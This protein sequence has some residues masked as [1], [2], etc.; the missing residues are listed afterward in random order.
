MDNK[1]EVLKIAD[2]IKDVKHRCRFYPISNAICVVCCLLLARL[3]YAIANSFNL[4]VITFI[5]FAT[6]YFVFGAFYLYFILTLDENNAK[7]VT[8]TYIGLR[9]T[10]NIRRTHNMYYHL[11]FSKYK[12][13]TFSYKSGY[14]NRENT[15]SYKVIKD[16]YQCGDEC[17]LLLYKNKWILQVYNTRFFEYK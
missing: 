5:V 11:R 17:Y 10:Y 1:K 6:V 13:Y 15:L 16:I 7:I 2:A 14:Y 3:S 4:F 9:E 12:E 8:D